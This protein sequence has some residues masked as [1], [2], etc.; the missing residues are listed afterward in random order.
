MV[1]WYELCGM[2]YGTTASAAI[3][4]HCRVDGHAKMQTKSQAKS[5]AKSPT[6]VSQVTWGGSHI[7]P[8]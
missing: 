7:D 8:T 6:C 3:F 1:V 4:V 5:R 2:W